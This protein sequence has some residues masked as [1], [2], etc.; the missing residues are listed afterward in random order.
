MNN[1]VLPH[2]IEAEKSLLGSLLVFPDAITNVVQIDLI[3]Q[4]FFDHNHSIIYERI[5][6]LYQHNS[7]VDLTSVSTALSN[8]NQLTSIGGIEYLFELTNGSISSASATHYATIIQEKAKRRNLIYKLDES[9]NKSFDEGSEL[10]DLLNDVEKGVLNVTRSHNTSDF[11][12]SGSVIDDVLSQVHLLREGKGITGIKVNYPEIDNIT[13]GFQRGDLI[14]LAARPSMGKTA[15]VLNLGLRAAKNSN[16]VVAMFSLEM[17]ADALMK[18]MLCAD[19]KIDSNKL[20]TGNFNE[21]EMAELII[22]ANRIKDYNIYIDETAGITMNEIFAKCR[23]L[24]ADKGL[25]MVIIDYLQLITTKGGRSEN[26][27]QEV[28][29]I[30]RELKML[31]REL[32]CPVIALSQLSRSVESR[33]DKRPMLS[34]LRES[35]SIEQDADLVIFLYREEYYKKDESKDKDAPDKTEINIAKHR[36]GLTDTVS[37]A[38]EKRYNYF[39]RYSND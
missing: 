28:S 36:N 22:A 38:F 17:P 26:R 27:V 10:I 12:D 25:D 13:N 32:E 18:R 7:I 19:G 24:K 9:I 33:Q 8:H 37:L 35:G 4:D 29:Q 31:A 6:M 21:K 11:Q 2:S 30:S 14:I 34:D 1:R 16:N 20:R 23:K 3:P 39:G 5:L 15:F